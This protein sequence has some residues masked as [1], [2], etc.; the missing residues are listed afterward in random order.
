M[1]LKDIRPALRTFL[2]A[3]GSIS[4]AVGGVRIYPV[5]LPSGVPAGPAIVYNLISE[6]TDHHMQG[7]SG[8]VFARYQIDAWATT[9]D[10]AQNLALLIKSRLDGYK[11]PMEYGTNSPKDFIT[12]LGVFSENALFD[13]DAAANLHRASR[14]FFIDY[15]ER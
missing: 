2:L 12:V 6:E 4:T 14:D 3:D 13:Y 15:G 11:G 5:K 1:T 7:A 8:L 10:L 9:S